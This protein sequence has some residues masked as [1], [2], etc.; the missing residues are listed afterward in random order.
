[1]IQ[2]WHVAVR[3]HQQFSAH[4]ILCAVGRSPVHHTHMV[5]SAQNISHRDG[6]ASQCI[7]CGPRVDPECTQR[8]DPE[9]TQSVPGGMVEEKREG[10]ITIVFSSLALRPTHLCLHGNCKSIQ[11]LFCCWFLGVKGQRLSV[12]RHCRVYLPLIL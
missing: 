5:S 6:F 10:Y 8:V 4:R 2:S 11:P 12:A 1:M 7:Q 3:D 9:W